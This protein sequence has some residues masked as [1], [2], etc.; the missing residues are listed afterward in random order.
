M[1]ENQKKT[2]HLD[3]EVECTRWGDTAWPDN[4][5]L[6]GLPMLPPLGDKCNLQVRTTT[7]EDDKKHPNDEN[8][9]G[10]QMQVENS[11][12]KGLCQTTINRKA[13]RLS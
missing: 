4:S 1:T 7:L 2:N 9:L 6:D 11:K 5:G 13:Q 8:E 10:S 12:P 3:N